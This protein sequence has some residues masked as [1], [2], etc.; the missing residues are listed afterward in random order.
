MSS[1][2]RKEVERVLSSDITGYQ[3]AKKA[4]LTPAKVYRLR[5]GKI[6]IDNLTLKSAEH[7]A[8]V[9]K[10]VEHREKE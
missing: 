6:S 2:L 9:L 8:S 4:G 1:D 10:E 7:L 5:N 3:L